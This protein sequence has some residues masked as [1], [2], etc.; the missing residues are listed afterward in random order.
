MILLLTFLC[1]TEIMKDFKVTSYDTQ[2]QS[3]LTSQTTIKKGMTMFECVFPGFV[4]W[5][6]KISCRSVC[7]STHL[8]HLMVTTI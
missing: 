5:E 1:N 8:R 2:R 7:R 4:E 3:R 6:H